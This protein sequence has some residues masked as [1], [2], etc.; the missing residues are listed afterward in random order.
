VHVQK[1]YQKHLFMLQIVFGCCVTCCNKAMSSAV[2]VLLSSASN[3]LHSML[4][5]CRVSLRAASCH[6]CCLC[7]AA[8]IK[9]RQQSNKKAAK[10]TDS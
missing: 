8:R 3:K 5:A 2:M 1:K 6:V 4:T 7:T 10:A 9:A